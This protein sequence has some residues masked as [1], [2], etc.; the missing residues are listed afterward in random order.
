MLSVQSAGSFLAYELISNLQMR[1]C[2]ELNVSLRTTESDSRLQGHAVIKCGYFLRSSDGLFIQRYRCKTCQKTFST[3]SLSPF[4]FQKKRNLNDIIFSLFASGTSQR[5]MAKI[6]RVNKKTIVR[7]FQVLGQ[8]CIDDMKSAK[9]LGHKQIKE[10]IFDDMETFEHTKLKP[11]SITMAVEAKSRVILDFRVS[12]MKAKGHLAERARKKYGNRADN[13]KKNLESM[14][15]HLKT[16]TI[17][18]PLI[19][20]DMNP[21]YTFPVKKIFPTSHHEVYKGKRGCVVGQGEL[22]AG[23]FDPIF[24]FNHTAAMLRANI[25]R[26]FRR[27]WNTT[28]KPK[29][30][31]YHIAIYIF[32]HNLRLLSPINN[33]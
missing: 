22:K 4:K 20:S 33:I 24:S 11:L 15:T 9:H 5:R 12:S 30:L 18:N 8:I 32:Y 31:E 29:C 26:L 16:L 23:G 27:T 1:C 14:L 10:F 3:E 17:Q 7:K 28:K 25:N 21:H 2:Y 19:K 6:L 13:R